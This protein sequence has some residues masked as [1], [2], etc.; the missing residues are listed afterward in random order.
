MSDTRAGQEIRSQHP[1]AYRSGQWALIT[2]TAKICAHENQT[3]G[4]YQLRWPDGATDD[5]AIEDPA[6]DYEYREAKETP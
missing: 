1:Y 3:R 5:W 6:A 4:C 2:G